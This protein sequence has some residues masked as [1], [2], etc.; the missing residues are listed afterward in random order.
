MGLPP[1][2][3][4]LLEVI[5]NLFVESFRESLV[6]VVRK[7]VR[8]GHGWRLRPHIRDGIRVWV[9]DRIRIR[10][11]LILIV[12]QPLITRGVGRNRVSF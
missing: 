4:Q 1:E 11:I 6:L 10:D 9:L 8:H 7:I 5:I 12:R 3:T 2:T